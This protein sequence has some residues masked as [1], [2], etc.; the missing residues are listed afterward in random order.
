MTTLSSQFAPEQ[1]KRNKARIIG[2]NTFEWHDANGDAVIRLHRTDIVRKHPDGSSTLNSDGWKTVTTKQRMNEHMPKGYSL[3]QVKGQW[4]VVR[5]IDFNRA[6]TPYYDG[7]N[8]PG[9]FEKANIEGNRVASKEA[10]LRK[11]VAK[12]VNGLD[13][14]SE[15]PEPCAGD[16]LY[17]QGI[18]GDNEDAGHL[19]S[20][21]EE[22][23]LH[24]SLIMNALQ[25]RNYP[26]PGLIFHMGNADLKAGRKPTIIKQALRRFLFAKLGLVR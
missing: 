17:C 18:F 3:S 15:L 2:N 8:V 4:Y 14:L 6:N 23:Y 12:F 19:L 7:I 11:Q 21:L 22:N 16:C 20:H 10:K 26:N 24:G 5:T 9:C 25:F 13:K 1:R